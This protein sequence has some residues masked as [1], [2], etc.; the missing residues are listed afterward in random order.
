MFDEL[1]WWFDQHGRDLP[2]REENTPPWH[3]LICEVMSQQTPIAR[4]LPAWT[5]WTQHWPTPSA[6]AQSSPEE[7]LRAWKSLG[8]PRRALRMRD[9]AQVIVER[10]DG[11]VP[12]TEEELLALPGIG[13]YTA[14]AILAF[15]FHKR[16]LVLDTNIRRVIG[17]IHGEALPSPTLTKPERERA[18]SLLPEDTAE[19]VVWNAA[20]MELGALVCTARSP[21][22][23][24]CPLIDRCG[25]RELGYPP[26]QHA[27][28]RKTQAWEGTLRQ[29]RGKIMGALRDSDHPLPVSELIAADPSQAELALAGLLEDGLVERLGDRVALPGSLKP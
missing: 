14:A 29:S 4:V 18:L 27:S 21:R 28:R 5:E 24:E 25:W 12:D 9:C 23:T 20:V 22:C 2:W 6:M 26:D 10:H 8:Y 3:I 1:A 19:S 7:V 15:G 17:R 11:E 13:A 16:A